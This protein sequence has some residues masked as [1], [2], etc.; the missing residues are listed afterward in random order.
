MPVESLVDASIGNA[1][2]DLTTYFQENAFTNDLL[3]RF[4]QEQNQ[5][6]GGKM[7]QYVLW[8]D[9][10]A[11]QSMGY[12]P[13]ASLP[14]PIWLGQNADKVTLLDHFFHAAFGGS[15][16]NHFWLISAQSPTYPAGVD[17]GLAATLD[18]AGKLEGVLDTTT[19]P[20][21]LVYNTGSNDGHLTPDG[22]V[23]NTSYSVNQPH[24]SVPTIQYIP[25]Q[26]F[27]TIGERPRHRRRVMGMVCGWVERGA[28]GR[29]YLVG[30]H[31]RGE[32][33]PRHRRHRSEHRSLRLPVPPPAV[34][35]LPELGW[36]GE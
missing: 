21:N 32:R 4:Y 25:Q 24:P 16:L 3:H 34:H 30:R 6:N 20:P 5:I 23:V 35:V 31:R 36:N 13:T 11:G 22:Y 7:D 15:F 12:W 8:N 18:D 14:V 28:R 33:H 2:F 17:A 26:T 1:P 19:T 29:R 27:K 9:E 10:S